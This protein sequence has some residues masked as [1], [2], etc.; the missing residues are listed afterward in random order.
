MKSYNSLS[1]IL[2]L[3]VVFHFSSDPVIGVDVSNDGEWVIWTTKEYVAVVNVT[4]QD[5]NLNVLNGFHH[6]MTE[7]VVF[8][9]LGLLTIEN[10]LCMLS[11]HSLG[12]AK[13]TSLAYSSRRY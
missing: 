8:V 10:S 12:I 5:E 3:R 9:L 6:S 11:T 7:K 4:F 1:T 13:C 2:L